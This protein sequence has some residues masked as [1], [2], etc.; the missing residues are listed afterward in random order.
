[1]LSELQHVAVEGRKE[2]PFGQSVVPSAKDAQQ[3]PQEVCFFPLEN[4]QFTLV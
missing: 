4:F 2:I 1:M 3:P